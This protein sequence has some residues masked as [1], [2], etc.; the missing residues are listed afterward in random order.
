MNQR[1]PI[2]LGEEKCTPLQSLII[3]IV[4][5]LLCAGALFCLGLLVLI[6]VG[7]VL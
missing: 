7:S 4:A 6:V 1:L 3:L 2:N 5:D